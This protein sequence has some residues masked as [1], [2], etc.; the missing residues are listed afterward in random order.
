VRVHPPTHHGRSRRHHDHRGHRRHRLQPRIEATAPD[1]CRGKALSREDSARPH[2]RHHFGGRRP[3]LDHRKHVSGPRRAS[4]LPS[5]GA[6]TRPQCR[7]PLIWFNTASVT[8][9]RTPSRCRPFALSGAGRECSKAQS[10]SGLNRLR[11]RPVA[12]SGAG[13]E[14][15]KA[16][17]IR[18]RPCSS[19]VFAAATRIVDLARAEFPDI[20]LYVRAR[21]HSLELLANGVRLRGARD[22]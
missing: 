20:K 13:R 19:A 5:H 2:Q 21:R 17:L 4:R 1:S 9:S 3:P 10:V 11:C 7:Q 18:A 12:L 15:S 22:L 16:A 8:S 6:G 14:C